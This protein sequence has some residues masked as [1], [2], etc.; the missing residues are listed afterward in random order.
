MDEQVVEVI[1]KIHALPT[2]TKT[3]NLGRSMIVRFWKDGPHR[4]ERV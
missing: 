4:K 3:R 1:L 2:N